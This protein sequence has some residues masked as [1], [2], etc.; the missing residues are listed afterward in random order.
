MGKRIS[1][2]TEQSSAELEK[3]YRQASDAVERSQRQIV[4]L[5]ASGHTTAEV[6]A[7]TGYGLLW[8]RTVVQRY[9]TT[10]SVGDRRHHNPGARQRSLLNEEQQTEL[11]QALEGSTPDGGLWS[12]AKVAAWMSERLGRPVSVVR[13]WEYLQ[14]L[15]YRPLMPRPRH[16]G[17]DAE[18]QEAFKK[19]ARHRTPGTSRTS[20]CPG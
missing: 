11:A 17:A 15:T 8:I 10:G 6:V 3:A 16:V 13:G 4:W 14:R 12:S 9:N 7:S 5:I 2:A 1:I 19:T 18:A 20:C